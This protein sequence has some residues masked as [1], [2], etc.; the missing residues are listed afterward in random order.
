MVPRPLERDPGLVVIDAT[1]GTIQPMMLEPGVQTIGELEVIEHLRAGRQLVD[2]R[3]DEFVG[4]GTIPGA[5]PIA[6]TH[7]AERSEE[8][9]AERPIALFCNGP[10]CAATP[11]AVRRLLAAGRAPEL[12]LYYRGG[13]HDWV[14]L[15]L[16][17][18]SAS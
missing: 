5:V 18:S 8:L 16:P 1:W 4:A 10:Q 9:D 12:I 3:V 7:I 14:S 11:D 13:L 15:G 6:H 2:T 17:V